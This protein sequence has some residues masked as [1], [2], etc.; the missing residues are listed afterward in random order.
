MATK[1]CDENVIKKR[2]KMS[3]QKQ[4]NKMTKNKKWKKTIIKSEKNVK[5]IN[6]KAI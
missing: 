5:K 1:K 3:T 2:G 6:K 4:Q